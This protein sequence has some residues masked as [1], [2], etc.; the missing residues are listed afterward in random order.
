MHERTQG[1]VYALTGPVT[2]NRALEHKQFNARF[3][4]YTCVQGS[5][6]NEHFQYID[7]PRGKWTHA[8][9]ESLIKED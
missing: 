5:F 7:K 8:K 1:G 6:T 4:R 2:L 9:N 3:Y